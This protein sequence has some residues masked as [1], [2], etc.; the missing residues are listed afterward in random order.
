MIDVDGR[1][2]GALI[3]VVQETYLLYFYAGFTVLQEIHHDAVIFHTQ[4][5]WQ[6]RLHMSES[7]QGSV[8]QVVPQYHTFPTLK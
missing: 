4:E 2:S 7:S 8:K 1:K 5:F 6:Q 3:F